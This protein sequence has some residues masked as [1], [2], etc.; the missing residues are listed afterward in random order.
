MRARCYLY[1]ATMLSLIVAAT[2]FTRTRENKPA[3]PESAATAVASPSKTCCSDGCC[4]ACNNCPDC[5]CPGCENCPDCSCPGCENCSECGRGS[6][7]S[8][9]KKSCCP[10]GD[11][12]PDGACCDSRKAVK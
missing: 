10:N 6:A 2:A 12:C 5:A 4:Q 11:C 1:A 8:K 9:A 7:A 3:A